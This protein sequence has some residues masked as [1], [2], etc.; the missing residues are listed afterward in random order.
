MTR[1]AVGS[2]DDVDGADAAH[3]ALDMAVDQLAGLAPRA[4]V[5]FCGAGLDTR[6]VLRVLASRLPGVPLIGGTTLAEISIHTGATEGSLVV[7]LFAGHSLEVAAV[8]FDLPSSGDGADAAGLT[9]AGRQAVAQAAASLPSPPRLCLC[10]GFQPTGPSDLFSTVLQA[11]G[12]EVPILGG[13]VVGRMTPDMHGEAFFG[14]RRLSPGAALLLLSGDV[15]VTHAVAHGFKPVGESH[16]IT[17]A[18]KGGTLL[19]VDGKPA[20]D[21]YL[22]HFGVSGGTGAMF[23]HHPLLVETE[24]AHLLRGAFAEGPVPG[25]VA[26]AG[27]VAEGSRVQLCEFDREGLLAATRTAMDQAMAQ[28]RGPSPAGVMV[29]ECLTRWYA[30]GTWAPRS[31]DRLRELVPA[32]TA[33]AGAYMGGEFAPFAQGRQGQLHNCSV[34]ALL[35]GSAES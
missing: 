17:R 14:E 1:I 34:V 10:F 4:A 25:S 18:L 29:F 3:A 22:S 35:I 31:L 23:V 20:L 26:L 6:E 11:L 9:L 21:F 8:A 2:S 32:R 12:P 16:T 7:V 33:I 28:W 24:D 15:Q 27:E 13:G 19:E 5:V 30:L